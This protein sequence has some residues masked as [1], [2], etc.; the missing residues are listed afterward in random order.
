MSQWLDSQKKSSSN[1]WK[2][3][4]ERIEKVNPRREL[5]TKETKRLVKLQG[6]ADKLKRGENVQNHRL[7]T[8]FGEEQYKLLNSNCDRRLKYSDSVPAPAVPFLVWSVGAAH[9]VIVL[10]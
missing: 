9:S 4:Q 2:L 3:L 6:I 5:T 10:E 8:R 1:I 7:K